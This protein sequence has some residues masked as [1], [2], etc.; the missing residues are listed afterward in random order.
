MTPEEK[1]LKGDLSYLSDQLDLAIKRFMTA[2]ALAAD[3]KSQVELFA[4]GILAMQDEIK[5]LRAELDS[6]NTD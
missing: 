4:V 3:Y 5:L 2:E 1:E 6:K